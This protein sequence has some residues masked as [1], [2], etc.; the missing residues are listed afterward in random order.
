MASLCV[1]SVVIADACMIDR[2]ID[3]DVREAPPQR[4]PARR[5]QPGTDMAAVSQRD[6]EGIGGQFWYEGA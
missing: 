3:C 5:P 4:F 6:I 2:V 1:F